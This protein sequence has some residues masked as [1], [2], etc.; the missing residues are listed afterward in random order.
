MFDKALLSKCIM[1]GEQEPYTVCK[2]GEACYG[3]FFRKM[4]QSK[5]HIDE[6]TYKTII[7]KII[8]F[9]TIDAYY[10]KDGI[11]LLGYKANMIALTI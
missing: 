9:K 1:S 10:G 8:L 6:E 11:N 7:A 4:T 3:A 5:V 2:G